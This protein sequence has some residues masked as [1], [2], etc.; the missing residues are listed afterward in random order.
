MDN[1]EVRRMVM[2]IIN[3]AKRN[4]AVN[5]KQEYEG[6]N[7]VELHYISGEGI[8][9]IL[10]YI[11]NGEHEELR[12]KFQK[13]KKGQEDSQLHNADELVNG[14]ITDLIKKVKVH[15]EKELRE[16]PVEK[17]ENKVVYLKEKKHHYDLRASPEISLE[18]NV[19][20]ALQ[21]ETKERRNGSL[22]EVL[23]K[24]LCSINARDVL[25][26]GMYAIMKDLEENGAYKLPKVI[27]IANHP[28]FKDVRQ[29]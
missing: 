7:M 26:E 4:L 27:P 22:M 18:K 15:G 14:K 17:P 9:Y 13:V 8:T 3:E 29:T 5:K 23:E 12:Q 21:I 10:S 1:D 20:C 25:K 6:I 2:K 11:F 16:Q 19:T 24:G 28:R